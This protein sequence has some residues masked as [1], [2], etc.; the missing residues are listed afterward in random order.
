MLVAVGMFRGAGGVVMVSKALSP[1][2]DLLQLPAEL[3]PMAI[4]R[5][6]SG[7]AT[8]GLFSELVKAHG[9]DSL[10][11]RMA[12]TLLGST[13]TTLYVVAVYFGA[14]G[15]KRA[16]HAVWAG[17]FADVVGILASVWICRA[18]FAGH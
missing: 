2:L 12:G 10:L 18:V 17:L 5:P 11:A 14:V 7:S 16:R 6:L 3:L 13:E 8:I 15:V 9:P 4:T 1:V